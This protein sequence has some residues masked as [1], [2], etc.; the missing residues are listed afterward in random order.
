MRKILEYFLK[1]S[2]FLNL[3]TLFIFVSGTLVLFTIQREAFPLVAM[4]IMT[5]STPYPGSSPKEVEKLVTIPIERALKE[6]DG[7]DKLHSVSIEGRST[8]IAVIFEDLSKRE[9]EKVKTDI[10]RAIDRVEDLP[11][12]VEKPSVQEIKTHQLSTIEVNLSGLPESELRAQLDILKDKLELIKGVASVVKR[13]WRDREFWIKVNPHQL[14]D[15]HL[16]IS[17]IV[18]S[19]QAQNI[20]LPGG[21]LK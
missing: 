6:V 10:Q 13:G 17:Q 3:L 5:I 9:K 18:A 12:E 11:K 20:N 2:L 4:D 19:L 15:L 7:I 8:V 16:S 1:Q 14:K 21:T